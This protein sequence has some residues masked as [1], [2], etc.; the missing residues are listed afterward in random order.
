MI[1]L[2]YHF[3]INKS[4]KYINEVTGEDG[5]CPTPIAQWKKQAIEELP[6]A[7]ISEASGREQGKE[8][9]RACL[10]EPIGQLNKVVTQ[11]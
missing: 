5:V 6:S 9:L 10:Y 2:K 1:E 4:E 11:P 7:F 8:M 3:R